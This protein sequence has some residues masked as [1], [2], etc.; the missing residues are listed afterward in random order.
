M[1]A[2]RNESQIFDVNKLIAGPNFNQIL[3]RTDLGFN[4][5]TI[6]FNIFNHK[7]SKSRNRQQAK[8]IFKR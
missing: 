6:K 3:V 1:P 7:T 2:G 5:N 8:S 4:V